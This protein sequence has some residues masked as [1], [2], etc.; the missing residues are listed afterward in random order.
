MTLNGDYPIVDTPLASYLV[1]QGVELIEIRYSQNERF[2]KRQGT[3]IFKDSPQ[4]R[5]CVNVY[6]RGEATVNLALYER[7]R[8]NLLDRIMRGLP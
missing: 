1:Q 7:T 5:Q 8:D 2:N 3:Y 6:N 4:L